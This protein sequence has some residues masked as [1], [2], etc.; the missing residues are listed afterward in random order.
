MLTADNKRIAAFDCGP[1]FVYNRVHQCIRQ[2]ISL[3]QTPHRY[4]ITT[5]F[6]CSLMNI[7]AILTFY[8]RCNLQIES[9][10]SGVSQMCTSEQVAIALPPTNLIT[11]KIFVYH[12]QL[13]VMIW[14]AIFINN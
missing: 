4:L 5:T 11:I 14:Q 1:I 7:I 8:L 2:R 6:R 3:C 12:L 10:R 13:V 9:F